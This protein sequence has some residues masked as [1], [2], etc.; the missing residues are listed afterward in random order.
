MSP[1]TDALSQRKLPTPTITISLFSIAVPMW[2]L[3]SLIPVDV[4]DT[5]DLKSS[6]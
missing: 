6:L 3:S 4:Q 5:S 1:S 2:P